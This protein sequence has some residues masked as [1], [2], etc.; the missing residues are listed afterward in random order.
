MHAKKGG[1]PKKQGLV[2]LFR[3]ATPPIELRFPLFLFLA[4]PSYLKK[5]TALISISPSN[6]HKLRFPAPSP[7]R[8]LSRRKEVGK[9][10]RPTTTA[11][12]S[13]PLFKALRSS[14]R[15]PCLPLGLSLDLQPKPFLFFSPFP[16][17][18]SLQPCSLSPPPSSSPPSSTPRPALFQAVRTGKY[19]SSF[20]LACFSKHLGELAFQS[21]SVGSRAFSFLTVTSSSS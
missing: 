18:L 5:L 10:D 13:P 6:H 2:D 19:T 3:A 7:S 4:L 9:G 1:G 12:L 14:R 20:P 21:S 8:F 11:S 15:G 17:F 16:F